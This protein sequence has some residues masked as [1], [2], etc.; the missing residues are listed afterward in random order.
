[1]NPN[2]AG[3]DVR[4]IGALAGLAPAA[5]A[6]VLLAA[7]G[8]SLSRDTFLWCALITIV[9][10]GG[11]WLIGPRVT[12]SIRSDLWAAVA[13]ALVGSIVY[14]LV[15][16]VMSIWTGP[17]A[18][19]DLSPGGLPVRLVSQ[20]LYGFLYLPFLIGWLSPFGLIWVLAVRVVRRATGV[21]AAGMAARGVPG[22]VVLGGISPRRMGLVAAALIAGYGLFVAWLPLLMYHEPRPPWATDRPVALFFLFSVPAWIAAI[23][24]IRNRRLLLGAAGVICLA[25]SYVAFSLV[26]IG[27]V[28][29]AIVLLAGA[30]GD[31]WPDTARE[32][33]AALAASVIAIALTM[34]AWVAT[35]GLTEEVC[36]TSTASPDGSLT[37]ERVPVSDVMTVL[38][39]Q[40]ASGCDSGTLTVEGMGAGAVLAIGAVAIAAASTWTRP[41]DR[42]PI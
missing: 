24:A 8:A 31:R 5:A 34:A 6:L 38:P 27:F 21:P 13:Y 10:L 35:L 16:T 26:T 42:A 9:A 14:V 18:G 30:A 7:L 22:R 12:G 19:I 20:A 3:R 37:Y 33:R 1:M 25:Q 29:P 11:G 32:P 28:V 2:L 4:R 40:A 17:A 23:G 39:G 36:W 41:A 15:G